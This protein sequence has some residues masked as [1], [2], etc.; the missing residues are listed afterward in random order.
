M[1]TNDN[2]QAALLAALTAIVAECM[3]CP[4]EPPYS[5]DSYLPPHLLE[6]ALQALERVDGS[7]AVNASLDVRRLETAEPKGRCELL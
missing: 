4:P 7:K 3:D 5:T 1:N 2:T 6:A